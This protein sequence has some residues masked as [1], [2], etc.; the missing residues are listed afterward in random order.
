MGFKFLNT[1]EVPDVPDHITMDEFNQLVQQQLTTQNRPSVFL[2]LNRNRNTIDENEWTYLLRQQRVNLIEFMWEQ[3]MIV[4]TIVS[5]DI[6]GFTL[7][8]E[9]NF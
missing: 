1:N 6:E 7:R 3:G 9:I 5:Q 4:Q 2:N 8:T